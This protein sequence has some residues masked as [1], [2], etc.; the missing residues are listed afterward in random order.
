MK[1]RYVLGIDPSG[2]FYEGKGTTGWCVFDRK[3]DKFIKCGAIQA[4]KCDSQNHYWM[5][6]RL[7]IDEVFN[8]YRAEGIAVSIEDYVLYS[9][10]ARAQV[11]S[12]M[13]TS[14]LLGVLKHVC[15][16]KS[17]ALYMR[18]ATHVKRRWADSILC[19]KGYIRKDG[20]SFFADCKAKVLCEHERDAM[21]HAV[22]CAT[23]ELKEEKRNERSKR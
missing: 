13:E 3:L 11:N 6:H 19:A 5:V 18:T 9:H 2:N 14:Q 21:R 1:I 8:D 22:H 15:Y 17:I 7:L 16:I 10:Q 20:S 12:A 23:F 4:S